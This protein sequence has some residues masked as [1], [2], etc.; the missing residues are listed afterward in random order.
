MCHKRAGQDTSKSSDHGKQETEELSQLRLTECNVGS[1]T[2]KGT[3]VEK[4]VKFK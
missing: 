1:W 3:S 4:L 2:R